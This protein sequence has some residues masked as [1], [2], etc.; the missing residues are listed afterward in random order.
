MTEISAGGVLFDKGEVFLLRKPN[1]EWVMPKGHLESGET[2]EEAAVREVFEETGL[3][4]R[5]V[6]KLGRTQY[7]FRT[8][9]GDIIRKVVHWYLMEVGSRELRVE[10]TF[11]EGVFLPAELAIKTLTFEN[12]RGIVRQA[13]EK[14]GQLRVKRHHISR[15]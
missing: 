11:E 14:L 10:P 4:A 13:I 2:P 8:P 5:I 15:K 7:R 1:G 12:D 3:K 9:N 6:S